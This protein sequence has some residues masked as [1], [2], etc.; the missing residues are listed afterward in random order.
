V[1]VP[2]HFSWSGDGNVLFQIT[3]VN[4]S[5]GHI[6]LL[7]WLDFKVSILLTTPNWVALSYSTLS[8][9]YKLG[10]TSQGPSILV[11]S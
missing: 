3:T 9:D 5:F 11:T 10:E 8:D 4:I 6:I 7:L 2:L 1:F